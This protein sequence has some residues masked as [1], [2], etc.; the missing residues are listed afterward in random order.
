MQLQIKLC[1]IV[2]HSWQTLLKVNLVKKYV[3]RKVLG[4]RKSFSLRFRPVKIWG[5]KGVKIKKLKCPRLGKGLIPIPVGIIIRYSTV[6]FTDKAVLKSS[7]SWA[8]VRLINQNSFI[9][10][11]FWFFRRRKML[12]FSTEIGAVTARSCLRWQ[13]NELYVGS[14][15][16]LR[17]IKKAKSL[18]K[19]AQKIRISKARSNTL[20][21][22][23][24]QNMTPFRDK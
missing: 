16:K 20:K 7:Q 13:Y 17:K 6:Y 3:S 15:A 1:I 18:M 12:K 10:L 19:L 14:Q 5:A 4:K 11:S 22:A 9:F 24:N 2:V 8:P 23:W 21:N